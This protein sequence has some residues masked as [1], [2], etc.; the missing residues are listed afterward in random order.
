[1]STLH[2]I[3]VIKRDK[4]AKKRVKLQIDSLSRLRDEDAISVKRFAFNLPHK[5]KIKGERKFLEARIILLLRGGE[6]G[7]RKDRSSEERMLAKGNR[8]SDFIGAICSLAPLVERLIRPSVGEA[9]G[10]LVFRSWRR[11]HVARGIRK[12]ASL[13]Y[14]NR[15]FYV[16]HSRSR[17]SSALADSLLCLPRKA[18]KARSIATS[19]RKNWNEA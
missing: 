8:F 11:V 18:R 14:S 1:M 16:Q 19:R 6:G 9:N 13:E 17:M 2:E 5:Q 7:R 12:F 10:V 3:S 4:E 15:V